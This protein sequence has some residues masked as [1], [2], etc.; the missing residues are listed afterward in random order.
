MLTFMKREG[1]DLLGRIPHLRG[2][3]LLHNQNRKNEYIWVTIWTSKS[4]LNRAIKSKAW[5]RLYVQEVASGTIFT[6]G[7]RRAHYDALL[8]L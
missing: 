2:A 1:W 4:G 3:Y 8:S 6:G 7:Y 5:K